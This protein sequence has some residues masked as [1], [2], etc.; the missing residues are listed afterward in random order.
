MH[1]AS[2]LVEIRWVPFFLGT[3]TLRL[4]GLSGG[5]SMTTLFFS[6]FSGP[7]RSLIH[8]AL[9]RVTLEV[10]LATQIPDAEEFELA[11][12]Y[13]AVGADVRRDAAG[14]QYMVSIAQ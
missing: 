2:L 14:I 6:R 10:T 3:S 7:F 4:F 5:L 1:Y 9:R 8:F 13:N 12:S 11:Y